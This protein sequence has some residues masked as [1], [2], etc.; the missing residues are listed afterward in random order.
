VNLPARLHLSEG[1]QV[2][3]YRIESYVA[4]GGMA[5]VYRARDLALG[6][7]VALKLIAPELAGNEKFRQRFMRESELA[8]SIDHPNIIPIYQAGETDGLLYIAMR[9][10]AGE[11]LGRLMQARGPLDPTLV[12]PVFTQVAAALDTAHAH[13]LVHRDVKPGNIL[14]AGDPVAPDE[15]H[16]YLT[17]FG[18]T[19]RSTSLSGFTTAGHFLG[20]I[21]YVAPEQIAG[22][23]VDFRVDIYA[24]GCILFEALAGVPP[25]QHEDD[26]AMLW[27]HVATPPPDLSAARPG[28]PRELDAVLQRA[29]AKD[30]D[31]RQPSCRAVIAEIRAAFRSGRVGDAAAQA[32]AGDEPVRSDPAPASAP[33]TPPR[34]TAQPPAQRPAQHLTESVAPTE[35]SAEQAQP[36]TQP[37]PG[38]VP[39]ADF[40]AEPATQN[41]PPPPTESPARAGRRSARTLAVLA[42]ALAVAIL[43]VVTFVVIGGRDDGPLLVSYPGDEPAVD[44]LTFEHPAAWGFHPTSIDACFCTAHLAPAFSGD[45]KT[46][47]QVDALAHSGSDVQGMVVKQTARYDLGAAPEVA[48]FVRLTLIRTKLSLGEPHPQTIGGRDGWRVDGALQYALNPATSLAFRYYLVNGDNK[49]DHLI[50]FTSSGGA[51]AFWPVADQVIASVRLRGST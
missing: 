37:T 12:L 22:Q 40:P 50:L 47:R 4:R 29:M 13:G 48:A 2:A 7:S 27:A 32:P 36:A 17:D 14:L 15:K 10:V 1:E 33:R 35:P 34:A 46:W 43:A 16:V 30:P 6:R 42:G 38:S 9:Y 25:F 26:A 24:M 23:A 41:V 51:D 45:A 3:G 44:W 5:V 20:T 11:D 39:R 18:L 19:K 31:E 28:L 8:A 49:T 21:A